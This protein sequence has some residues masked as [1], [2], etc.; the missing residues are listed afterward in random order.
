MGAWYGLPDI[1]NMIAI[2]R[3]IHPVILV[4]LI[5]QQQ[6]LLPLGVQYPALMRVRRALVR[7]A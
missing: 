6:E 7:G 1:R 2:R 5:I 3:G 4:V